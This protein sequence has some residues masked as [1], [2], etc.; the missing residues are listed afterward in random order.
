MIAEVMI[1]RCIEA[2][3]GPGCSV[4]PACEREVFFDQSEIADLDEARLG[5]IYDTS[6]DEIV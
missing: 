6:G 3:G 2:G 4:V 5:W 1:G